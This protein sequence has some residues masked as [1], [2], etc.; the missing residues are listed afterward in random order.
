MRVFTVV[1]ILNKIL[2]CVHLADVVVVSADAQK[3][4]IGADGLAH[5]L[6]QVGDGH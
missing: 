1:L 3:Q 2:G 5:G 4:Q 6:R